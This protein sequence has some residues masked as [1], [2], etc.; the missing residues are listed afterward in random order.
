[1]SPPGQPPSSPDR[2]VSAQRLLAACRGAASL[3]LIRWG[4]ETGVDV[5]TLFS[6][7]DTDA[8]WP[9]LADFATWVPEVPGEAWPAPEEAVAAAMD[10]GCDLIHPGWGA[11]ARSPAFVDQLSMTSLAWA[12][13]SHGA[14]GIVC[15]RAIA[16]EQAAE[17]GIPVVPGS[18]PIEAVEDG[19]RWVQQVGLPVV[20]KPIDVVAEAGRGVATT[21][22]QATR[23]LEA[24]LD[25][26][27]VL[28]ERHVVGAREVEVPLLVDATGR[29]WVMG[30][31][32]ISARGPSGRVLVEGPAPG[33]DPEHRQRMH[34]AAAQ[35]AESLR[36]RGLGTVRFLV[37]PDGRPYLLQLRPGLQPWHGVTERLFGVDLVDAQLR[38]ALGESL[39]WGNAP[40]TPRG[41]ALWLALRAAT[42]GTVTGL[43]G[44]GHRLDPALA[45][46]DTVEAGG[47]L[48]SLVV[49]GP[50]RQ[51][52]LVLL[53]AALDAGPTAGVAIQRAE[54]DRLINVPEFWQR[55][56]DRDRVAALLKH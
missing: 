30:D 20:V 52:A 44:A 6:D 49:G 12:G 34:V 42:T 17:L 43:E 45:L 16:R 37:P 46:G 18:L 11:L 40:P 14:T 4:R 9:E 28:V 2:T 23:V 54:I 26:G 36:Y 25:H 15:D 10:A 53:R 29:S 32:E 22:A 31:R 55:S 5:V 13:P 38:L 3:R 56:L 21:L 47:L 50:T 8:N 33:L 27:P 35:F 7:K 51:A 1:M 41:H 24:A 48:G 39:A 19:L